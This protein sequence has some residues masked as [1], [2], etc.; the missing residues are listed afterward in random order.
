MKR[1]ITFLQSKIK[2][3]IIESLKICPQSTLDLP[4]KPSP[5]LTKIKIDP[6]SI[7]PKPPLKPCLSIELVQTTD[8]PPTQPIHDAYLPQNLKDVS[9]RSQPPPQLSKLPNQKTY[10][11]SCQKVFETKGD[12]KYHQDT[13]YGRE[14]CYLLRSMLP[15]SN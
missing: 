2:S 3:P 9:L 13:Q 6:I 11:T 15:F 4:P 7:E 14:D 8:I 1:L 12:E 5:P 10:C